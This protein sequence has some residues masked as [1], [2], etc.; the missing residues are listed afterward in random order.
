MRRYK[1]PPLLLFSGNWRLYS[2]HFQDYAKFKIKPRVPNYRTT[3]EGCHRPLA[4]FETS[5]WSGVLGPAGWKIKP[6]QTGI[7]LHYY[8]LGFIL[9]VRQ[10]PI[11][12]CSHVIQENHFL[13][14]P[15]F[16]LVA[17]PSIIFLAIADS[18]YIHIL[19]SLLMI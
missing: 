16:I 19:L 18:I 14:I 11:W 13:P 9:E 15:H 5:E 10:N 1:Q 6:F 12:N 17:H 3:K 4:L 7:H 8:L 2:C